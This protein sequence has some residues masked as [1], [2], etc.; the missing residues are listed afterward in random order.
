MLA[1]I[2]LQFERPGW[3]VLLLLLL[4]VVL[5]A[6]RTWRS[7]G[8]GKAWTS[9]LLRLAV[10]LLLTASLA[11]PSLV[12][13]GE[14]LTLMVVA[15][16]SLSV[17]LRLRQRSEE[18][19]Q[20]L[21]ETKPPED[22]VGTVVVGRTAEI[23]SRPE[24]NAIVPGLSHSGD[25]E[26][27]N[28]AEGLRQAMAILPRDTASRILLVSDFNENI[29]DVLK[30][31]DVAKANGIPV[32]VL[33]LEY[34]HPNEVVF[35]GM[36]V[37]ARARLGQTAEA[38]L[39]LR[40]QGPARGRVVL[41]MNGA[42]IDLDPS[43][44]GDAVELELP[45]GPTA[46]QVP[47]S[48]DGSGAQ[49]FEATFEPFDP[50]DDAI[51]ENNVAVG[52]TFVSGGGQVLIVDETGV[53]SEAVATAL[54]L[55]GLRVDVRQPTV[56]E[57]GA[58]LMNGYDA[59]LL[60]NVPRY[61]I[62]GNADRA[63]RSYVHDLGGG[64]LMLGGPNSFGAGGWID[65]E[66]SK[67]LPVRLDPPATRQM[68]R[69]ALAL[70]VHSCE[71]P[72][73]NFWSQQVAIAAIEALTRLDLVGILVFGFGGSAWH[74]PLQEVGDKSRPI[75]AVRSMVVGDMPDFESSVSLAYEG[76]SK[77]NVGQRHI[78][79]ISDGDPSPP[80]QGLLQR[81][82]QGKITITTVMV[83]GHG[84]PQDY[85]NMK[86][87]AEFTGG[88]FYEVKQPRQLPQI[89]TKEASVVTR[90]LINEGNFQPQVVSGLPGPIR[91]FGGLPRIRG[92][93][94]TV[95]REGLAQTPMVVPSNDGTDPLYAWWN[96][97]VGRAVAFT[98]DATG[99][100]ANAWLDWGE[101]RA[102]WEQTVRWLMRPA[103]PPN[104]SLR[105]RVEGERAIVELEAVGEESGFANF[106][107]A[108]AT[109][110]SPD[111]A[112][113]PLELQ[114]VGPGRYRGEFDA[115]ETGSYLVNVAL[116]TAGA[117]AGEAV[118]TVQAA[119]SVPYPKEF[120]T[121]RDNAALARQVA[122]R[123][124]GRVLALSNDPLALD[125]FRRDGLEV[126]ASAKRIWDLMAILAA[127][128]FLIDVAV[129][130][131]AWEPGAARTLAEKALGRTEAVGEATV[132]AWKKARSKADARGDRA[133]EGG[134]GGSAQERASRGEERRR[135]ADVRFDEESPGSLDVAGEV[136]G[137]RPRRPGDAVAKPDDP[138]AV[139]EDPTTAR[140]LKA[141]RRA[142][143]DARSDG[144]SAEGTAEGQ[145]DGPTGG[146]DRRG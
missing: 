78:I 13:R 71:M 68:V 27:T 131:I 19:L 22:R 76:L 52:I 11:Q 54:R 128:L 79:I 58:A 35:E 59:I 50:A 117:A 48:F 47:V 49:R 61:A 118:A 82:R 46:I 145:T 127:A 93:V 96:H 134:A 5:L 2:P 41:T 91:G 119:V 105:T 122:E 70:I 40:S 21:P 101:F 57:Q 10:V 99:R 132:A 26:A 106:L 146:G 86:T 64:L 16:R 81:I 85:Q 90:S 97:G 15:D 112:A 108:Q 28:L 129:R 139:A 92:Y 17:P 102:F 94:V 74:F 136:G 80:S 137:E 69:G 75:A 9:L 141:R 73:A 84:T 25:V 36:R 114:Q 111:G 63:L 124:G 3:L 32:D 62:D 7:S 14:G 115:K 4:P 65:S 53:D 23:L 121:V 56:L 24:T 20:K 130:R 95:P 113:S 109:V 123:T 140:L 6:R 51:R 107:R 133:A 45:A 103:A 120:R 72:Q 88:R 126:P 142:R 34:E 60:A 87:T 1:L 104:A 42:P 12:K 100:W 43:A 29:E 125:A 30:E 98:S 39:F 116:P 31:A 66:V 110:L 138:P 33:P 44:P 38:R 67:V 37:P 55:A 18:L 135:A 89:F 144:G 8:R 83:A 143:G 77:V